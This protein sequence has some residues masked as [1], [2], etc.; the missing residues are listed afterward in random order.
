MASILL[1]AAA[2]HGMQ[3]TFHLEPYSG[4][5]AQS[6]IENI[7]YIVGNYG[8]HRGFY[9]DAQTRRP[10]FYVYDSYLTPPHEWFAL[11]RVVL[12][13]AHARR[14]VLQ[15]G[16]GPLR[17]SEFDSDVIGLLVEQRHIDELAAG[18]FGL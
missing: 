11:L 15:P 4:R 8:E 12:T 1:E 5:S 14:T 18:G 7:K 9:R 10:L 6:T 13:H 2:Q 3:L 17:G 16:S